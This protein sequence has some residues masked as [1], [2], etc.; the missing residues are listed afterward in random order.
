ME[1]IGFIGLGIMGRPMALHLAKA[2]YGLTVWARRPEALAP[3][4]LAGARA[5]GSPKDVAEESEVVVTMVSDT[6]DVEEVIFGS[7]GIVHGARPGTVVVDMSTVSPGAT[8]SVAERLAAQGIDMLDAPVSGGEIGAIQ[9]TLSIMVGGK[10]EVF[11]RVKPLFHCMGRNIVHIGGNGA[12]Q[13][14]K[15]CNQILAAVTIEAVAEALSFAI[16]AGA[17]PMRVREALMGGFAYS[18]ALEFHGKRMLEGDFKPGFKSRLFQ[19]DLRIVLDSAHAM[20]LAL[21]AAAVVAQHF[22]AQVG[23]GEG[24]LDGNSLFR[25]IERLSRKEQD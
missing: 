13:V 18:K 7:E 17:D 1:R 3:L 4:V 6:P 14:A 20:G 8:R 10:L 11:E 19:K 25:V 12:G 21:P 2:G 22:N 15:S 23:A 9:G 16:R 5:A 24:D